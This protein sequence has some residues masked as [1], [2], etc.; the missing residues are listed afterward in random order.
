MYFVQLRFLEHLLCQAW[1][2]SFELH[3]NRTDKVPLVF[4]SFRGEN[5]KITE[6]K[7]K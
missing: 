4:R 5:R 1:G 7:Y 2:C 3:E 6:I